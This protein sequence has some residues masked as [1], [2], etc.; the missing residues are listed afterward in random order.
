MHDMKYDQAEADGDDV[1]QHDEDDLREE[2][3]RRGH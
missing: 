2:I 1:Q 3:L